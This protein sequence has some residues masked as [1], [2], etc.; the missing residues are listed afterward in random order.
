MLAE[1]LQER[2]AAEGDAEGDERDVG[3]AARQ[4]VRDEIEVRRLAG[5][6]KARAAIRNRAQHVL[7]IARARAPVDGGG[8]ESAARDDGER[9][10]D[11]DRMRAAFEA[12]KEN[13]MWSRC[14]FDMIE[15]QLVA[16]RRGQ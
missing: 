14:A 1:P 2:V 10:L 8:A 12:V 5:V 15:N 11:R 4:R 16:V 9:T 7:R 13:E 3:I 6:I